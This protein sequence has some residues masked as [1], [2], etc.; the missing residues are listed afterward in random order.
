[1]PITPSEDKLAV[2]NLLKND[3]YLKSLG[4]SDFY[5]TNTTDEKLINGKQQIFVYNAQS[6]DNRYNSSTIEMILQ[7]DI[8]VPL[9]MASKADRAINQAIA[10]LQGIQFN[11][12]G[13]MEV[14]APS[15]TSVACQS[16]FY[17]VAARLSYYTSKFNKIKTV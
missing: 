5:N 7:I 9:S 1:M 8:S 15:P 13:P 17:C 6:R 16:G 11:D 10:L 12:N 3:G 2:I 4:F 14:I